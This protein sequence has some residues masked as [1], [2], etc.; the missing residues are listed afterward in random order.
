MQYF[1]YFS[2][3]TVVRRTRLIVKVCTYILVLCQPWY[4]GCRLDVSIIDSYLQLCTRGLHYCVRRTQNCEQL[5]VRRTNL[6]EM[7]EIHASMCGTDGWLKISHFSSVGAFFFIQMNPVHFI[8]ALEMQNF[9]NLLTPS[10]FFTYHQ[11]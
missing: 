5:C 6:L 4:L 1:L 7:Q 11:V 3:V 10:G 8:V 9:I 2:T